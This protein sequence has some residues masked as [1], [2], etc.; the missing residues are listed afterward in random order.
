MTSYLTRYLLYDKRGRVVVSQAPSRISCRVSQS[1]ILFA[2][3]FESSVTGGVTHGMHGPLQSRHCKACTRCS[4]GIR[5][6][7]SSS[8]IDRPPHPICP[9]P[10]DAPRVHAAHGHCCLSVLRVIPR[11]QDVAPFLDLRT[12]S[13][14]C[15]NKLYNINLHAEL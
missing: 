3:K 8:D 7:S 15:K 6:F 14:Y 13:L 11:F 10:R 5:C 2:S 1:P 12:N 9:M 4:L